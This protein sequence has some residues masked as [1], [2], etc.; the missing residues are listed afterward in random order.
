MKDRPWGITRIAKLRWPRRES[1]C[2]LVIFWRRNMFLRCRECAVICLMGGTPSYRWSLAWCR[3]IPEL[4]RGLLFFPLTGERRGIQSSVWVW[5][6]KRLNCHE[7]ERRFFFFFYIFIYLFIFIL[8]IYL[9]IYFLFIYFLFIYFF[10]F[11]FI[12]F[13]FYF[14][15]FFI[16]LFYF[17]IIIIFFLNWCGG[18]RAQERFEPLWAGFRNGA[19]RLGQ[20]DLGCA[21][22]QKLQMWRKR[23][24]GNV[25][26]L[27]L[28]LLQIGVWFNW[29]T[30]WSG[31]SLRWEEDGRGIWFWNGT[32]GHRG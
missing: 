20:T 5:K 8:F 22:L 23:Q 2:C 26:T 6:G 10:I 29:S 9:F 21:S 31:P 24:L 18:V 14:F 28:N 4:Y 13:L 12:Y 32:E 3:G 17:I 30:W 11:I 15:Y 7:E 25:Q 19:G 16:L 27:R 1:S